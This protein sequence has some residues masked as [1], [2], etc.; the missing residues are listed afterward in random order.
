M[1]RSRFVG[2]T[3]LRQGQRRVADWFGVSLGPTSLPASAKVLMGTLNAAALDVRPFTIVRTRVTMF[4]ESD[5]SV[6]SEITRGV[7]GLIIVSDQAV[8]AGSASVPGPVTN[9]D[10]PFFVYEPFVNSFSFATASGFV[11]PA[12][13]IVQ[14]DS[15]AMRKVSS[16]ENLAIILENATALG[17][18]VSLQG[19]FLVKMH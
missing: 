13:T 15:K 10:A 2:R 3:P 9:S 17:A 16:G 11:E 12:G 8:A 1:A 19:R 7:L 18:I 4:V 5:Q 6:A 14:I